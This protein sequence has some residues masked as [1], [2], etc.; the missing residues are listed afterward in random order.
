MIV[1]IDSEANFLANIECM[2]WVWLCYDVH[3]WGV[4]SLT[5]QFIGA[6]TEALESQDLLK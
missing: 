1:C 2:L 4:L 3:S 6:L 5:L